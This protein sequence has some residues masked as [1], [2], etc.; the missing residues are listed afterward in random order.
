MI[1]AERHQHILKNLRK[2]GSVRV[3]ELADSLKV[4]PE[5]IRR[6]LDKLAAERLVIRGHGGAI[7][8]STPPVD[9]SFAER[10]NMMIAEKEAIVKEAVSLIEHGDTIILDASTTSYCL[11]QILPEAALTVLTNSYHIITYLSTRQD[12]QLVGIGGSLD[13]TSMSFLGPTAEAILERYSA[14]KAF[15]SCR[16]IDLEKGATDSN[17]FHVSLK[18]RIV[19]NARC[20]FLLADYSKFGVKALASYSDLGRFDAVYTDTKLDKSFA[21]KI[22]QEGT[23]LHRVKAN[24][25]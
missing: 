25:K 13:R 15:L 8:I 23:E 11:A 17:E 12:I 16:G 9:V 4:A 20:K 1:A 14:D 5:T 3:M 22:R 10:Q 2:S 7:S 19:Q 24:H 6:D 18:K 21:K